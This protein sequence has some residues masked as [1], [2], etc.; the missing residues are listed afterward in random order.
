MSPRKTRAIR[1]RLGRYAV[2]EK[3][4]LG[5]LGDGNGTVKVPG[6]NNAVYVRPEG[7]DLP[8]IVTNYNVPNAD[9]LLVHI[10]RQDGELT[11]TRFVPVP[12]W[13]PS[14]NPTVGP[15]ASSHLYGGPDVV[16]ASSRQIV[17]LAVYPSSGLVVAVRGGVVAT[18]TGFVQ[19]MPTTVDLSAKVPGSDMI[20]ILIAVTLSTGA[21]TT[22][23]GTGFALEAYSLT[24]IPA[25]DAGT[26]AL[27]AVRL[28]AG[29]TSIGATYADP[30]IIDLRFTDAASAGTSNDTY[31]IHDNVSGEIAAV[32]EKATPIGADLILIEDSAASNAKKRATL[33]NLSKGID[34]G[35]LAGLADDDHTQYLLA[36]GARPLSG[37]WNVGTGRQIQCASFAPSTGDNEIIFSASGATF[38]M[39]DTGTMAVNPAVGEWL[40]STG[41]IVAVESKFI[42]NDVAGNV[43]LENISGTTFAINMGVNQR[44]TL[45]ADGNLAVDGTVTGTNSVTNGNSH[46]HAGGDG[47]QIDHGGLAGLADDDHTQYLLANATRALSADWD[48]GDGRMIQADKVRARDAAGLLLFEDGGFG[49]TIA[50]GGGVSLARSGAGYL[51]TLGDQTLTE[52]AT[53]FNTGFYA[54]DASN[55]AFT[56]VRTTATVAML[57]GGVTGDSYRRILVDVSGKMNWGPG[58]GT[59]DAALERSGTARL[60]VTNDL[61]AL[62]TLYAGGDSGGIASTTALTNATVAASSGTG[63]VKMGG[64]TNRD[65]VGWLKGYVGTTAV[66]VPYWTTVTG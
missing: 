52:G 37:N 27:A 7:H 13:D 45:D 46:D 65:S 56:M 64:A 8:Q 23:D 55:P 42:L 29:Q 51:L 35:G 11:V 57:Q 47:A 10:R 50:D 66:Y 62:G 28:R 15:H 58:S 59:R 3:P 60:K 14:F 24:K 54:A 26:L 1:K 38:T 12:G 9:G 49:I 32:T 61:H 36:S 63:A 19:V 40:S 21:V 17:E 22:K 41:D 18:S 30:D 39:T 20:F 4:R 53:T 25:P 16:F 31:A 34:H 2:L 48:I 6:R 5:R 43:E 44:L 33:T